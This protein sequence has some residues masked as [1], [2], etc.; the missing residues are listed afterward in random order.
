MGIGPGGLPS[1]FELFHLDDA[2][3]RGKMTPRVDRHHPQDL[4]WRAAV[5]DRGRVLA[6]P[7]GR[8]LAGARPRVMPKPYQQPHPPIAVAGMSPYPFFVKEAPGA[9]GW[10][11]APTSFPPPASPRIGS[12][13]VRAAGSGRRAGWRAL[14]RRA[15]GAGHRDRCRGCG[16]PGTTRERGPLLLLLPQR[17]DEEGGLRA[18]H[19]G[20]GAVQGRLS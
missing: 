20:P 17:A 3:A 18:D 14:A 5:S 2:M 11:S 19:E 1:D 12:G 10:R 6:D 15:H 8:V 16:L 4:D 7:P 9:A 13:S